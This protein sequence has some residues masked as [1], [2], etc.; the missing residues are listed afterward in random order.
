MTEATEGQPEAPLAT[1]EVATASVPVVTEATDG[2]P[3]APVPV[4][5]EATDGQPQAPGTGVPPGTS[6]VATATESLPATFTGAA[7]KSE[8][9]PVLA[10]LVVVAGMMILI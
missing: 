7:S 4:V 9:K 2:Q 8:S 10:A 3:Q 5:T 1:S 6:E